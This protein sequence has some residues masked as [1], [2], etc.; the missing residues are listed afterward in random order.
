MNDLDATTGPVSARTDS[1]WGSTLGLNRVAKPS[2]PG[3]VAEKFEGLL[4]QQMI[5]SM[6][7]T[8]P[9]SEVFGGTGSDVARSM[10]D[11]TLAT[12]VAH[13]G[14]FGLKDALLRALHSAPDS[15]PT[16]HLPKDGAGLELNGP[17]GP[18]SGG[19]EP[20]KEGQEP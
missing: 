6:R 20:R 8:V 13:A 11:E 1:G 5:Q 19:R 14:G 2:D 17:G 3:Q 10:L 9:D 15:S 18:L 12:S 7:A 4:I 16:V